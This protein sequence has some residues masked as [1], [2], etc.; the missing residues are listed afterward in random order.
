M[1]KI[2]IKVILISFGYFLACAVGDITSH[3]LTIWWELNSDYTSFEKKFLFPLFNAFLS[4]YF[5][6]KFNYYLLEK[7]EVESNRYTFLN[8]ILLP[9]LVVIYMLYIEI[10]VNYYGLDDDWKNGFVILFSYVFFTVALYL[11]NLSIDLLKEK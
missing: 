4:G 9:S 10:A 3:L 11:K 2:Q 5:A 1:N 7:F 6:Y 8:N